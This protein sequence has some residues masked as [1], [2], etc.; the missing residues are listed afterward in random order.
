MNQTN[1]YFGWIN[2]QLIKVAKFINRSAK[3][4]D[5][6]KRFDRERIRNIRKEIDDESNRIYNS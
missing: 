4:Y 1:H 5:A 3:N 6:E 2:N